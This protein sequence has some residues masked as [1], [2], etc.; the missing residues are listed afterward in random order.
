MRI[1]LSIPGLTG[2]CEAL[3]AEIFLRLRF[4]TPQRLSGLV[5]K[6]PNATITCGVRV[7]ERKKMAAAGD[8]KAILAALIA[9]AGISIAKF[10]GFIFTHSS[11]LLAESVHSVADASN[12]FLLLMGVQ[13]SNRPATKEHP[14]GYGRERYFW[15]FVV[16]VVLF[17]AGAVF[18]LYEG[19]EKLLHPEPIS[20]YQWAIGILV[21]GLI[22]EGFSLR[23]AI[24]EANKLRKGQT[25]REFVTKSKKPELPVVVL[26]DMGAMLGLAFA[27]IAIVLSKV[28]GDPIWDGVGTVSI[29]VLLAIIAI[30]L[31]KEMYSLLIGE[32]VT[33]KNRS[34]IQ[35]AIDGSAS[36]SR[37][38][39]LR[40]QHLGPEHILVGAQ[41]VFEPSLN[42][43]EVCT[44]IEEIEIRIKAVVPDVHSIFVEPKSS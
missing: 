5:L 36:V 27:L 12:Q 20:H 3:V 38:E 26:E 34:L 10:V 9:N 39:N 25:W 15:S 23:T 2:G 14:F 13:R 40:T 33:E 32:G 11:A 35:E 21:F 19:I 7:S 37:I 28:T 8:K 4:A 17:T 41:V 22:L 43:E 1:G 31:A 44:A 29:G 42:A 30:V 24:I 18:A 6:K 16:S